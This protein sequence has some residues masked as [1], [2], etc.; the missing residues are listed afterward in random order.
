MDRALWHDNGTSAK[1]AKIALNPNFIKFKCLAA[2]FYKIHFS[3]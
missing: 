2:E 1:I 3:F